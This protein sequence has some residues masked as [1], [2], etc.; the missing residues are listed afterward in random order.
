MTRSPNLVLE[1]IGKIKIPSINSR[2]KK[3]PV[4][5]LRYSVIGITQNFFLSYFLRYPLQYES[6][7]QEKHQIFFARHKIIFS[8]LFRLPPTQQES[9]ELRL[10]PVGLNIG[11]KVLLALMRLG[12]FYL[13]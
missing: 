10:E 11:Q 12:S 7:Q 4:F 6:F 1:G 2:L 9:L 8:S 5:L 13:S 3:T